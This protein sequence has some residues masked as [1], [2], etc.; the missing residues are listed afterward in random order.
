MTKTVTNLNVKVKIIFRD[1]L[2]IELIKNPK[3]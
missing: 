1:E 2:V 3:W